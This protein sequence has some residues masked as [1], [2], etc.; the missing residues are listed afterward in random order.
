[1]NSIVTVINNRI[2]QLGLK[3]VY[4]SEHAHMNPELLSRTLRGDRKLKADEFVS[5]CQ[6]LGLTLDDF[7]TPQAS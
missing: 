6:V 1:M 4:V 7:K 3:Q 5:L 2:D